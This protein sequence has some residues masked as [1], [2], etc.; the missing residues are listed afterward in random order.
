MHTTKMIIKIKTWRNIRRHGSIDVLVDVLNLICEMIKINVI[1]GR[2]S[3]SFGFGRLRKKI[4]DLIK[5]IGRRTLCR[6]GLVREC[7]GERRRW[8]RTNPM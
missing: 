7:L 1:R 2:G 4:E 3:S 5:A 8:L 6:E